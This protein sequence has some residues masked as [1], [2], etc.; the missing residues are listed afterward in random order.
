MCTNAVLAQK[1]LLLR[2]SALLSYRSVHSETQ[3]TISRVNSCQSRVV[4]RTHQTPLRHCQT[5][6]ATCRLK[7]PRLTRH[8]R[9]SN[10]RTLQRHMDLRAYAAGSQA[11]AFLGSC[12]RSPFMNIRR[13]WRSARA[14]LHGRKSGRK[15][16]K[17]GLAGLTEVNGRCMKLRTST[18][19]LKEAK[20]P[21]SN[22]NKRRGHGMFGFHLS[23]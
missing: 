21:T 15:S 17:R 1:L 3:P 23:Q 13:R 19:V 9:R 8:R 18:P 7:F 10:Q 14:D 16:N 5:E 6:L 20:L 4:H 2:V 12:E 22:R 11:R